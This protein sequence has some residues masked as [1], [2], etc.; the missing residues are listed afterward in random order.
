MEKAIIKSKIAEIALS[1]HRR[2]QKILSIA[3]SLNSGAILLG[4]ELY[5][6]QENKE[7]SA[8]GY[9]T[10]EAYLGM[11][12]LSFK[13]KTAYVLMAIYRTFVLQ[14][15]YEPDRVSEAEWS[16]LSLIMP[17]LNVQPNA[18][19]DWFNKALALSVSD[20]KV[21]IADFQGKEPPKPHCISCPIKGHCPK[22]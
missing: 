19:K 5:E 22:P 21:E 9:D 20:L 10:F 2:H 1:A 16:K 3:R 4:K 11:P 6:L 14:L 8:L 13:R 17:I 7:Y 18:H 12:E 15:G